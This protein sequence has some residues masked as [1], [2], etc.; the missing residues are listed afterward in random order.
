MKGIPKKNITDLAKESL[1]LVQLE[2]AG[3][4]IVKTYSGGMKRRLSLA[5]SCI[6]NVIVMLLDEPTTGMDP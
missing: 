6:G 4:R 3:E 2:D 5:M 1:K